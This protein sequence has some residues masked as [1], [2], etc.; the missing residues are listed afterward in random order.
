MHPVSSLSHPIWQQ[1]DLGE[2]RNA[3]LAFAAGAPNAHGN[4][5]HGANSPGTTIKATAR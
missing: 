5:S 4:D 3:P 1:A 2:N